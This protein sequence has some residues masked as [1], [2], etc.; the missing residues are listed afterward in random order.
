MPGIDWAALH[1]GRPFLPGVE[2]GCGGARNT[3]IAPQRQHRNGDLL[4]GVEIG[5]VDV[6]VG[7]GAG[8]SVIVII[9]AMLATLAE[10][11]NHFP[12]ADIRERS[13][14]TMIRSTP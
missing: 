7:I 10:E 12:T 11:E 8:A 4:A 14:H 1:I 9:S 3:G 5:L 13:M 2:R 6:V